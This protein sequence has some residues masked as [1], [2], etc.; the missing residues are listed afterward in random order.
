MKIDFTQ[1]PTPALIRALDEQ[2]ALIKFDV[3]DGTITADRTLML[4]DEIRQGLAE[5]KKRNEQ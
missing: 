2:C 1:V 3:Q 5:L 4:V